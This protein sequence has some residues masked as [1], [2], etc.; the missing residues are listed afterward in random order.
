MNNKD[1]YINSLSRLIETLNEDEKLALEKLNR[2]DLVMGEIDS[3]RQ[4][5]RRAIEKLQTA[6]IDEAVC[7]PSVI[8]ESIESV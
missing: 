3:I 7:Y 2:I 5:K 1:A 8:F 4:Q 6:L